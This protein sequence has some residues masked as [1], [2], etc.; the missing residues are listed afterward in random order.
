MLKG[1]HILITGAS[2]GIGR[3]VTL[4]LAHEEVNLHL[5]GRDAEA[6]R[7][8]ARILRQRLRRR[9]YHWCLRRRG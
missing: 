4:L 7:I 2:S 1:T 9:L 6:A 8:L 3:A 5:V